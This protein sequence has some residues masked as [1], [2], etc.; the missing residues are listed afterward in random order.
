MIPFYGVE[1]YAGIVRSYILCEIKLEKPCIAVR[2]GMRIL[3][4]MMRVPEFLFS[5]WLS[6]VLYHR[7][8]MHGGS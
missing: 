5:Y 4:P 3:H 8:Q 1:K 7:V 6:F 2:P